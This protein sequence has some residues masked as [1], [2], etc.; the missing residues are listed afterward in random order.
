[1]FTEFQK[2]TWKS[3]KKQLKEVYKSNI[4]NIWLL[5]LLVILFQ[6]KTEKK[7]DQCS[8]LV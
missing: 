2:V 4:L 6:A 8:A 1:M 7:K 5:W 3:S